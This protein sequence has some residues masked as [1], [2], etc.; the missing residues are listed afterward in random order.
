MKPRRMSGARIAGLAMG[1]VLMIGSGG[2]TVA[3][4]VD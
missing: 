3:G 2:I 1:L 4:A